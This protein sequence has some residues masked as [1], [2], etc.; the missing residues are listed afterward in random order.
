MMVEEFLIKRYIAIAV[1]TSNK[2]MVG[3]IFTHVVDRS[4]E[5]HAA[6]RWIG[7]KV[8]FPNLYPH[9]F[10]AIPWYAHRT[11]EELE[12]VKYAK[13]I[14]TS[15][16]WVPGDIVPVTKFFYEN[17]KPLKFDLSGHQFYASNIEPSSEEE[18]KKF[19]G[20]QP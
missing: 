5:I 7:V 4:W 17:D 10:K 20:K 15:N 13:V 8:D 12:S 9:L 19:K 16:Y 11:I 18:Y 1:D 6:G 3:D 14:R 2:F